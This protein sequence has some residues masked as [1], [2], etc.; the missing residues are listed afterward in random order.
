MLNDEIL[1]SFIDIALFI[2]QM[3]RS[4]MGKKKNVQTKISSVDLVTET[5]KQVEEFLKKGFK[6]N[7]PDHRLALAFICLL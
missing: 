4:A 2:F 6:T 3:V 1:F 7:F 5:D